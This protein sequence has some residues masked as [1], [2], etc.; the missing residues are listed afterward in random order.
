MSDCKLPK[1]ELGEL[2]RSDAKAEADYIV[3][4]GWESRG[5]TPPSHARWYSLRVDKADA[6]WLF[7]RGHGSRTVASSELLG[8]LVSVH[9]FCS[10]ADFAPGAGRM[11]CSGGTDNQGNSFVVQKLM[12]TK[13]PLAPILMQLTTLL[14][15]RGLWLELD[16][17][18]REDNQPADDLT[19]SE[20][21]R[22]DL[23]KRIPFHW[24]KLPCDVLSSLLQEGK[25][26][27]AEM[28]LRKRSK[29]QPDLHHS[30]RRFRKRRKASV[31]AAGE[32]LL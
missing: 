12:T 27:E 18:P 2:F 9:L 10:G 21:G 26:F 11:R 5:G 25:S 30:A 20:F 31:W 6:P 7:E 23:S 3:L 1:A 22:F 32:D 16:W 14:A 29:T 28:K 17:V 15:R 19:N 24:S 4:G 13:Y 8:T